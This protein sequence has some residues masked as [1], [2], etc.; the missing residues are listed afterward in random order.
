MHA[1]FQNHTYAHK[2]THTH[3]YIHTCVNLCMYTNTKNTFICT[4]MYAHAHAQTHTFVRVSFHPHI[5]TVLFLYICNTF[6]TYV[7]MYT[8]IYVCGS[9]C[10]YIFMDCSTREHTARNSKLQKKLPAISAS[11]RTLSGLLA[12]SGYAC[13]SAAT[14]S[15]PTLFAPAWCS[16]GLSSCAIQGKERRKLATPA[17]FASGAARVC[18]LIIYLYVCLHTHTRACALKITHSRTHTYMCK[19]MHA[20][21]YTHSQTNAH[22]RTPAQTH[23]RVSTNLIFYPSCTHTLLY[24]C[25]KSCLCIQMFMYM[26]KYIYVYMYML[27]VYNI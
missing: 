7:Y 14:T 10:I 21:T 11:Q 6:C 3:T 18:F 4:H 8:C 2:T 17:W 24:L 5:Y 15:S 1:Y 20:Y 13:S 23:T 19:L 9:E 25:N 16:G 27:H 22:S 26:Y 12:A